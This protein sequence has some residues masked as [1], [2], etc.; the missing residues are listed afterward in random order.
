MN[1]ALRALALCT[2]LLAPLA[3]HAAPPSDAS[4]DT[5]IAVTHADRMSE[6][7]SAGL[8]PMMRQMMASMSQGQKFTAE[9]QRAFDN[10]VANMTKVVREE[11]SWEKMKP[12]TM[13]I[14][15][16]VFT[17]EEVDG[18]IAFYRTPAGASMVEK[19]PLVVQKSMTL[20]QSRM[21]PMMQKMQAAMRQ[22]VADARAAK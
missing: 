18:M 12:V 19:M 17:Q 20:M 10:M 3:A 11:I 8:D 2:A 9:Q 22:A 6:N 13:Q 5:L 7:V 4:I 15:R 21:V 16:E 1:K 14:Y